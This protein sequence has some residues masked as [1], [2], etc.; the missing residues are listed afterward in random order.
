MIA[1]QFGD[2]KDVMNTNESV[3]DFLK[4]YFGYEHDFVGVTAGVVLG[5][6][7]LFGF[8]FAYSIKAFNF[9]RR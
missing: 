6:T 3:E 8:I 9:Q 1:S 4:S 7:V 2:V 5:F